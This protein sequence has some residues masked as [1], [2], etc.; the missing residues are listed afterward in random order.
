MISI[1]MLYPKTTDSTFNW[2]YFISTHIKRIHEIFDPFG[3]VRVQLH[4]GMGSALPGQPPPY[5]CLCEFNFETLEGFQ[6]GFMAE[7][8][9]IM[10]DIHNYT[11]VQP[12]VQISSLIDISR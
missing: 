9:W 6:K 3:L 2:D 5:A 7:G 10:G 1:I 11:N 8:A 4:S 12:L